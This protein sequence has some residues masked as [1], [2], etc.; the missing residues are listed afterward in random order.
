MLVIHYNLPVFLPRPALS[1]RTGKRSPGVAMKFELYQRQEIVLFLKE[2]EQNTPPH[3]HNFIEL[4]LPQDNPISVTIDTADPIHVWPGEILL[5]PPFIA[6]HI[7]AENTDDRRT[8]L[9]INLQ[10]LYLMLA[11]TPYA[12]QIEHFYQIGSNGRVY[13]NETATQLAEIIDRIG[14]EYTLRNFSDIVHVIDILCQERPSDEWMVP[15]KKTTREMNLCATLN[16]MVDNNP[17]IDINLDELAQQFNMSKSTFCRFFKKHFGVSFHTWLLEKKVKAACCY[18]QEPDMSI[19]AISYQLGFSS[20]SHFTKVFKQ[21]TGTTPKE[22]RDNPLDF[23]R[24]ENDALY[25]DDHDMPF[26]R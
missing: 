21:L 15:N 12:P 1:A 16:D 8:T 6:H 14:N 24:T 25:S 4:I 17:G 23:P 19:Q 3:Y 20:P 22:F 11:N 7:E 10:K 18:L 26:Y 5:I 13:L 9:K 2:S